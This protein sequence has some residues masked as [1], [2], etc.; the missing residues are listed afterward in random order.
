M[1]LDRLLFASVGGILLSTM[2]SLAQLGH[3]HLV[4]NLGSRFVSWDIQHDQ[5][6][7]TGHD[8]CTMET[9]NG[10]AR[11]VFALRKDVERSY[12]KQ[13]IFDPGL[14]FIYAQLQTVTTVFD[15][16][17]AGKSWSGDGSGTGPVVDMRVPGGDAFDH[18][19]GQLLSATMVSFVVA[20]HV[21]TLE[22]GGVGPAFA[23]FQDCIASVTTRDGRW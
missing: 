10:G 3:Q 5:E 18:Y 4:G 2:P 20:D 13:R 19:L 16:D 15:A 22:L 6:D 17:I 8:I 11:G 9:S 14:H 23:A 12:Y 1:A 21:W 7:G